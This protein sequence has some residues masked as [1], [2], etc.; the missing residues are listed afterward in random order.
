MANR[1]GLLCLPIALIVLI[2]GCSQSARVEPAQANNSG[3]S[4]ASSASG[5][6]DVN[7][8]QAVNEP[9]SGLKVVLIAPAKTPSAGKHTLEF[10][11]LDSA[12]R[13]VTGA[14]IGAAIAMTNMDMGT[15]TPKVVE[16][17]VGHYTADVVFSMA[18]PWRATLVIT[19]PN[20]QPATRELDFAVSG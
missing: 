7:S 14:K 13:P 11:V 3:A 1:T 17:K 2:G 4:A 20:Q 10:S 5:S 15:S 9:G 18:G 19:P 12:G 8:V 16:G 6:A